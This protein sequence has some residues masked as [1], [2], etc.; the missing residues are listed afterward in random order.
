[1]DHPPFTLKKLS[2]E[3]LDQST[4]LLRYAFQVTD[5]TLRECGWVDEEI[6][7]SKSSVLEHTNI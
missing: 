2:V 6:K 5:N 4:D 1:M 3:H 7:Q